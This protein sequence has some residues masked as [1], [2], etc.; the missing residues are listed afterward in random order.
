M[1]ELVA[2][3]AGYREM[4]LLVFFRLAGVF[5]FA[6]VLGHRSLPLAHRAGLAAGVALLLAPVLGPS[7]SGL[8]D[9]W[10]GLAL[11]V[12]GEVFLGLAIGL[13]AA[14]IVATVRGAGEII[15]FHMGLGLAAAYDPAM[16]QQATELTRFQ[17]TLALV[18]F[19]AVNGHHVLIQAVAA[20]FRHVPAGSQF[21]SAG[22]AAGLLPLGGKVFRS[23][24]ELAAP[25]VGILFVVNVALALLTRVAPQMNIFAVGIPVAL[26]A[27][28]LGLV[29]TLPRFFHVITR[30][31]AGLGADL[32]AVLRTIGP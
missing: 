10:L 12:A 32:A 8:G 19:L 1:A 13:V 16:G 9:T 3:T 18:L 27:G 20:S 17:E 23:S 31:L 15:G 6:P 29:E 22:V 5:A 14:A 28:I 24:L 25:V 11:A 30:L 2:L 26:A 4:F 21:V 7:R